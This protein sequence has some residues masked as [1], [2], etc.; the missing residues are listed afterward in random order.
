[1]A[2]LSPM[3]LTVAVLALSAAPAAFAADPLVEGARLCTQQFPVQEQ[4]KGIPAHLLAAISSTESGRWHNELGL[5]LPWPWT[6]NVEGKGYYFDSKA[7]AIAKT[8]AFIRGGARSIDVGCMQVNLKHH[9]KAFRSLDEAFDPATNVA[10]S[11]RFLRSNYDELG[12][13]IKATAAYHSRTHHRGKEY[14]A[15][16]EK[17]W[18]RIVAKVQQARSRQGMPAMDVTAPR[19]EVASVAPTTKTGRPMRPIASTRNVRV[20]EVGSQQPVH[21]DVL[22]IRRTD[23]VTPA[24]VTAPAPAAAPDMMVQGTGDSIRRVAID[25]RGVPANSSGSSTRFVFAN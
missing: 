11:A 20:I 13:W 18:N 2:F 10:Y 8:A 14:L 21:S 23:N 9:A 15:R 1:M 7:E 19:F 22:V 16:I 12:D 25:N 4:S 17:S 3:R 5:A 6:I 24:I